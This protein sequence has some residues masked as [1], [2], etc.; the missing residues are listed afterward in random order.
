MTTRPRQTDVA[1]GQ[2]TRDNLGALEQRVYSTETSLNSFK[3]EVRSNQRDTTGLINAM[4]ADLGARI[5]RQ[6]AKPTNWLQ[7]LGAAGTVLG[8]LGSFGFY[9]K[10]SLDT[11]IARQDRNLQIEEQERK[12]DGDKF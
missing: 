8:V 6:A 10:S 12:Q 1:Y 9:V 3:E 5:D 2:R 7:F 4:Q 11:D